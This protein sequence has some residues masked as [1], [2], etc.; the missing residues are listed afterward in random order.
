M[1]IKLYI[2]SFFLIFSCE[3][4]IDNPISE[5]DYIA[6]NTELLVRIKNTNKFKNSFKNNEYLNSLLAKKD[7]KFLKNIF[8]VLDSIKSD[9]PLL[10][11]FYK[12]DKFYFNIIGKSLQLDSISDIY[13]FE[14][15]NITIFSNNSKIERNR[16][17]K[18]SLYEKFEKINKTNT[19]F[20]LSF[21][22]INSKKVIEKIFI[23]DSITRYGNLYVNIDSD[24]KMTYINGVIDNFY[25]KN[26]NLK[27]A[28]SLDD[29]RNSEIDFEINFDDNILTDFQAI[30]ATSIDSI[31]FFDFENIKSDLKSFKLFQLNF[32]NE[33]GNIN[34]I[35]STQKKEVKE[36]E[37]PNLFKVSFSDPII[38]GPF[39]VKNH[40]TQNEEI[41]VQDIN[42]IL[43]LIDNS[44][45]IAWSKQ[46]DE[47]M[48]NKVFQI[49]SYK[50][51]RL[52]YIFSTESKLYM[53]DRKGR[54]VGKFPLKFNDKITLPIS[55]FD[56]DKNKN[57]R[58]CIAQGNELFMFDSKG[59]FVNGFKYKKQDQII[60]S[61]K[62]FR[63]Q[64]KDLIVFKTKSKFNIINRRGEIR[65]KLKSDVKFSNDNIYSYQNNL[66]STSKNNEILKIDLKGNINKMKEDN[67]NRI[68]VVS[69]NDYFS[70]LINNSIK[71]Q[72]NKI[73]LEFG[74]YSDLSLHENK[75][76]IFISLYNEQSKKLYMFDKKLILISNFPKTIN[77]NA[78]TK[79]SKNNFY[80]S[81]LEDNNSVSLNS[82]SI[83]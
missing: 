50:N 75:K 28:K 19:N 70:Y 42:N 54:D 79:L 40:I 24:N 81:F 20:S 26:N 11:C 69:N 29:I 65:I 71:T 25:S 78:V 53:L 45:K 73:D 31:N 83:Q 14:D 5:K 33:V 82:V 41:I 57:Y 59:T 63:I 76:N 36:I 27:A 47:K 16:I 35:I 60:T 23:N 8:N 43:Y 17:S 68:F 10:I 9:N 46:I 3:N 62:H 4:I 51:G 48:I 52:Q 39:I 66:I 18:N 22:S 7:N 49:D 38:V 15:E 30:S 61:P 21:D 80:Y 64:D 74:K 37:D 44:G 13:K 58:I 77:S 1:K 67:S 55:V 12:S 32:G 2:L 6:P 56:Y 72:K 34:G